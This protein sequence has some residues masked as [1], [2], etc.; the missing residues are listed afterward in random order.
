VLQ[1][2]QQLA[3]NLTATA[4]DAASAADAAAAAAAT[5]AHSRCC[6]LLEVCN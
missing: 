4:A 6:C 5:D 1:L 2:S 3:G